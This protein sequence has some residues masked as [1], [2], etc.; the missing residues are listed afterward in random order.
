MRLVCSLAMLGSLLAFPLLG[1]EVKRKDPVPY[2]L[3]GSISGNQQKM[4]DVAL[5]RDLN[6][7]RTLVLRAG[8][9]F[10]ANSQYLLQSIGD[11]HVIIL[12]GNTAMRYDYAPWDQPTENKS[13]SDS[14][15]D[16]DEA[17]SEIDDY[18][19]DDPQLQE[20]ALTQAHYSALYLRYLN[21]I[22][23]EAPSEDSPAKEEREPSEPAEE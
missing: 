23:S 5:I 3:V 6:A 22:L 17:Y 21:R 1:V 7:D 2:R 18:E 19:Q 4:Q 10:G 9:R 13:Q 16:L 12:Q 20:Q 14:P 8:E 11:K 15:V